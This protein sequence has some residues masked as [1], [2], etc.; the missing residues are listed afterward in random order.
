LKTPRP[1]ALYDHLYGQESDVVAIKLADAKAQLSE[2][3]DR[4]EAGDSTLPGVAS[5][6]RG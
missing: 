4:V 3:I 2:L 5:R 1:D 6:S